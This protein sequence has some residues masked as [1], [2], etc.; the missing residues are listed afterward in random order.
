[1]YH[2]SGITGA[3]PIWHDFMVWALKG[4]PPADF[5][6]PDGMVEVE[7]CALSGKLPNHNCTHRRHELFI[8]GTEPTGECDI[9][10]VFR[11]DAA[12]GLQAT[13]STPPDR[14]HE[15]VYAVYPPEALAWAVGQGI[16]QPPPLPGERPVEQAAGPDA[17]PRAPIEIV[18]PFQM[19][20]Y[21][22]SNALPP[23]DQQI[24][25]EARPGGQIGFAAVTLYLD[26]EPLQTFYQAPYRLWW[27]LWP[28]T[29]EIYAVGETADGQEYVSESITLIVDG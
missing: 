21:R 18:S 12:T 10:Q 13:E 1:M 23:E 28:G 2:V 26:G 17:G 27:Q 11:I 9:H 25:I 19:D 14:V 3:G 7:V 4:R 16:P 24:M 22:V 15:R 20:R 6:R 29:H 5:E 8:E